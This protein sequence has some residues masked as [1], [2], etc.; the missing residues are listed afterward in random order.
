M[1]EFI[2]IRGACEHNLKNIEVK[3][4]K[5][6]LVVF[7]G[8]S[9]SGKSSLAFDTIFAE[10]Q[11]RYVE[12]LSAYAR[13][14][15]GQMEKPKYEWIRGLAPTIAI[16]QKSAGS[17]PR[18]TVG[19]ITEIHDY[20]RVLFARAGDQKCY[21]C[22]RSVSKQDVSQI[23]RE[24]L[25]LPAETKL[26]IL[27]PLA[28][29]RKGEFRDIM[30]EAR[31]RGFN[32]IRLDGRIH[33]LAGTIEIDRNKKHNLEILVD[34]I[35]LR[36]GV[37][38]RVTDSIETALKYGNGRVVISFEDGKE[39]LYSEFLACEYCS[40]S[41]P[42]LSP[43]LFSF[44]SPIGMCRTC[45]GLGFTMMVDENKVVPDNRLSLVQGAVQPW[46]RRIEAAEGWAYEIMYGLS[47]KFGI[48]L[49]IPFRDLPDE[50]KKIIF[51]GDSRPVHVRW[52]T[53]NV[54]ARVRIRFEG[55]S[56]MIKRRFYETK[57]EEM[58]E[59]YRR[60]FRNVPCNDCHGTRLRP[61]ARS[62]YIG[63][64]NISDI[65][66]MSVGECLNFFDM[67]TLTGNKAVISE[68]PVKE[69]RSRLSFL[70]NLGLSYITLSRIS[71]TLSGGEA[72][73]IRLAS[74]LGSEL[75]GVIYILDEPSIGL[76]PK[77][78]RKMLNNLKRLRDLGNTVLVVEHDREAINAAD[79]VIDFGPGAGKDGGEIVFS[80]GPEKLILSSKTMTGKYISGDMKIEIPAKRRKGS[81]FLRLNNASE[82]NL[83]SIDVEFPTGVFTVV[84]GVSGAG[85]STLVNQ[86]LYP[87]LANM[88]NGSQISCGKYGS[89]ENTELIDKVI[90]VNQD[91][92]GRTPRSN[93][94]TYTKVFDHI[95][96]LFSLTRESRMY[97]YDAGRFS[98]NVKGGRCEKCQ[99]AGV[100]RIAMHFLP[101]IFI[102]CEECHG[103]RFNEATL[104]VRYK[105][106][107]VSDVLN[108]TVNECFEVFYEHRRISR[109][110]ETLKKVGLGYIELGQPSP[111][112]SGGEAQR[113]KLSRELAKV[114]TGKTL[115]IM[116][117]PSTG[118][119]FDDVRKLLGV[120]NELVNMNNTVIM[121]EH[122][123]D[124]IKTADYIV[125]LGP[126]GGEMGGRIVATGTPEEV[127]MNRE[128]YTGQWL[129]KILFRN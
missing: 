35:A 65:S 33:D 2:H 16:E 91:P 98:F 124:I 52:E 12:S 97:G 72:Q 55:V 123:M 105:G 63:G 74:Q 44:N 112:L 22:G 18:S 27:S 8:V 127:M 87:A 64:K 75:T 46:S 60:F 92:I 84:T 117:E 62:V 54:N 57:S 115:Y 25:L 89:I 68:E 90:D 101:D 49:E 70:S 42:E 128:S 88:L 13:Q 78:N 94:A 26:L 80:G 9:G 21:S 79:H 14:F 6:K 51:Y 120:I 45:N 48:N 34:R 118:L 86:V 129:R 29:N 30:E 47:R 110:L 59:Y 104:R 99:G 111:T 1:D 43:Q 102:R 85:K 103:K 116:D 37:T 126:E 28:M 50:H 69:I 15:L 93:P 77:D 32:R 11:R 113:V 3:I 38:S 121:I 106:L 66:N 24:I 17:N 107:T 56:N 39:N 96:H 19:T 40:L 58:R 95:R 125:D 73:R 53:T 23:V 122:N 71:A 10:G 83:K 81:C 67:L 108:L 100:I 109:I 82:N 20:F 5:R 76:H 119:H 36:D 114:S 7:T 41:F 4:P 61:E 31:H